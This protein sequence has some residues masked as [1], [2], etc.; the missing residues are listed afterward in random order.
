MFKYFIG[1]S[2][3]GFIYFKLSWNFL[4]NDFVIVEKKNKQ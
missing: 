3:L 4:K 1:I 2:I